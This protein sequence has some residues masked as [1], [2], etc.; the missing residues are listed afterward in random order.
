LDSVGVFP[1][2]IQAVSKVY[3]AV[4]YY[5]NYYRAS[6][7]SADAFLPGSTEVH[8]ALAIEVGRTNTRFA[9][10]GILFWPG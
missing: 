9:W 7:V 2:T 3:N 6:R 1:P 5:T 8:G 10:L 4:D